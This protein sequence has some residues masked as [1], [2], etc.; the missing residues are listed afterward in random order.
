MTAEACIARAIETIKQRHFLDDMNDKAKNGTL[1]ELEN[2][3]KE[4]ERLR[5]AAV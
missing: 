5:D 1:G 4:L 2:A 3:K